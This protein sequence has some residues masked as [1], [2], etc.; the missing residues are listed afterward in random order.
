MWFLRETTQGKRSGIKVGDKNAEK[1]DG[2]G[3]ERSKKNEHVEWGGD[4]S[5]GE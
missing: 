5:F 1:R 2:E 3:D 4:S